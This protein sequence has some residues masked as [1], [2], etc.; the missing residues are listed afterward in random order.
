MLQQLRSD[1]ERLKQF[2][3]YT[4]VLRVS[5]TMF[6]TFS[7]W[8]LSLVLDPVRG[9]SIES[10]A[11]VFFTLLVGLVFAV[12]LIIVPTNLFH[13]ILLPFVAFSFY[14]TSVREGVLGLVLFPIVA[15][16]ILSLVRLIIATAN[17]IN[18]F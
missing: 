11:F 14:V 12:L 15:L 5:N 3:L 6:A 9:L 7:F 4:Q 8:N 10:P 2:P 17:R 1:Y 16:G 18:R 13:L